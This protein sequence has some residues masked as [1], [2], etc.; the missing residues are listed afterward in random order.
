MTRAASTLEPPG[1]EKNNQLLHLVIEGEF[2][3]YDGV[4]F[5]GRSKRDS[6]EIYP[7]YGSAQIAWKAKAHLSIDDAPMAY[8]IVRRWLDPAAIKA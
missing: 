1:C 2:E 4:R 5:G 6:V 8:F 3:P 7:D